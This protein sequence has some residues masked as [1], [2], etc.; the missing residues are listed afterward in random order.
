MIAQASQQVVGWHLDTTGRFLD[1]APPIE[2]SAEKNILWKTLMPNWSNSS[3]LLVGDR[4]FVCSEP[5]TLVCVRA[6]DG[7]ILWQRTNTYLDMLSP[8]EVD[9]IRQKL[10]EVDIENTTKISDRLRRNWIKPRMT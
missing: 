7:E 9:I 6:S 2:W 8:E 1:A 10:E 3:P 5:T 4:I